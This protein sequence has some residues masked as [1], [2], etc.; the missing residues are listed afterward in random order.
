MHLHK[1]RGLD[2][3]PKNLDLKSVMFTIQVSGVFNE[4]LK[5]L[6][7]MGIVNAPEADQNE[8]RNFF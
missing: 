4:S 5:V 6:V 2:F 8:R 1:G 7:A 3:V